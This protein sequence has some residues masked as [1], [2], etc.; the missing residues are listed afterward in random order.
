MDLL[1]IAANIATIVAGIIAAVTA[2][3]GIIKFIPKLWRTFK[4]RQNQKIQSSNTQNDDRK[5][6]STSVSSSVTT[7]NPAILQNPTPP[8]TP[9]PPSPTIPPPTIF[10]PDKSDTFITGSPILHPRNFFGRK[11]ELRRL[12]NLLKNHPLQNAAVIGKRRSGKTSLLRYLE[13]ITI[14][15]QEELRPDQKSDWLSNPQMY[16]WIF[17][18]FQNPLMTNREKLL[19]CILKGLNLP[20]PDDCTLENFMD[21]V[22]DTLS[23]PT[24]ILMDEV[25][26]GLERCPE[27]DDSF[28]ESLRSWTSHYAGGNL[29]FILSTPE[30]PMDLARHNGRSS[31]FFNIFGYTANIGAFS[32]AEARE[33][34]ASSP[35]QFPEPD[36]EWI[37]SESRC[38][39]FLVQILCRERLVSLED[40][41]TGDE[42]KQ[43]ALQQLRNPRYWS[44]ES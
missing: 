19:N 4:F 38:W 5:L 9:D 26:V 8:P 10:A 13:K 11:R 34:I 12:F 29:A 42:W 39:P 14:T 2:G 28:W 17:I 37:L 7:S 35:I 43:E 3:I 31:P 16:R 1:T 40:G 25:S 41:E 22:G 20:V 18:D 23:Q 44:E 32:E 36:V 33:L 15:P 24:V 30:S 27:L 21:I 6:Q